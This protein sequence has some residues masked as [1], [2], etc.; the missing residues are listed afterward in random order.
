MTPPD[1][2]LSEEE[3]RKVNRALVILYVAMFLMAAVP[4]AVLWWLGR[5]K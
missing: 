1:R 2:P 5:G 3:K 4:F